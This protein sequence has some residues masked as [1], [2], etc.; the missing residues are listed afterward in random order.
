MKSEFGELVFF[1]AACFHMADKVPHINARVIMTG[2]FCDR[3]KA[4]I[5]VDE[6]GYMRLVY[7]KIA[8]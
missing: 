4:E 7:R 6:I 5:P 2:K 8:K 1:C 3:C